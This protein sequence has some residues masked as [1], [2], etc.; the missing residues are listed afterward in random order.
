PF[1]QYTI[2][3]NALAG[4]VIQQP[5]PNQNVFCVP[6]TA[7]A[8]CN[9][10]QVS[11]TANYPFRGQVFSRT[12]TFDILGATCG[13]TASVDRP[14][15]PATGNLETVHVTFG[16]PDGTKPPQVQTGAAPLAQL[17]R[18]EI[19]PD[20]TLS[21]PGNVVNVSNGTTLQLKADPGLT[22]ALL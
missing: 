22:Y 5:A 21:R 12:A 17:T 19:Y 6:A 18:V 4:C 11:L 15:L 20:V 1:I 9:G 10:K 16:A 3:G 13:V 8:E 14:V 7:G 2:G